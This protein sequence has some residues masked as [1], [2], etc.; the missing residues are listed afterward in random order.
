[1]PIRGAPRGCASPSFNEAEAR[2]PRMLV[3]IHRNHHQRA[4]SM[5]PRRARLGCRAR[6]RTLP[7]YRD[8]FNEAEARAP[9]MHLR[10]QSGGSY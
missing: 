10:Q 1:M 7:N 4:A 5:R 9:R 3:G 6:E 2:A 8:G